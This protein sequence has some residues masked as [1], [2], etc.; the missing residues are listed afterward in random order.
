MPPG[1]P[2][3]YAAAPRS[4]ADGNP[5]AGG[6]SGPSVSVMSASTAKSLAERAASAIQRTLG[7][8]GAAGA[9][10]SMY[11]GMPPGWGA[12]LSAAQL[13]AAYHQHTRQSRRLYVGNI[14]RVNPPVSADAIT[15]FFNDAMIASGAAINPAAG[16]P[17]VTTTLNAEKGFAFVEFLAMEDAESALMFNDVPFQSGKLAVRRPKDYDAALNPLV[18]KRGGVDSAAAA[19]AMANRNAIGAAPELPVGVVASR[20]GGEPVT[21]SAPPKIAG[22]WGRVP[23]RV[24][25]GPNKLYAGG[26]DPLHGETQAR[27]IL[28]AVGVLKSFAPVPDAAGK[29]SGHCFFEYADARLTGIAQEALTG[30]SLDAGVNTSAFD[31]PRR[32]SRRLV[33][34]VAD[35]TS[36]AEGKERR[37]DVPAFTYAVP[38]SAAALLGEVAQETH[39]TSVLWVYNAVTAE[40]LAADAMVRDVESCVR[41]EAAREAEWDEASIESS[42]PDGNGY[43]VLAFQEG[44]GVGSADSGRSAADAAAQCA[45]RL[46]GRTF[47]GRE[48]F[49]RYAPL[50]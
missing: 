2:G 7:L 47:E 23:R 25:D 17:V 3:G 22:E 11:P 40:H 42:R 49:V 27:Q 10:P 50:S 20:I 33:C 32:A 13:Q 36:A 34:R 38:S 6:S 37:R 18:V 21:L 4:A 28:Q 1:P 14:P 35:P 39:A 15:A 8:V 48:L 26:F 46:N 19:E 9:D 43:L 29:F 16:D 30:V 12:G 44:G 45:S 41:L 24:P 5:F 31:E